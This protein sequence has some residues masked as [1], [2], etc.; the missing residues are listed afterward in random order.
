VEPWAPRVEEQL[1]LKRSDEDDVGFDPALQTLQ[2]TQSCRP[3]LIRPRE[4]DLESVVPRD[5]RGRPGKLLIALLNEP[6]K[7]SRTRPQTRID[8]RERVLPVGLAHDEVS[9]RLQQRQECDKKEEEPASETAEA[10]FQ[11]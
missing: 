7:N 3:I 4:G 6:A 10:K 2:R 11:G 5:N 9:R 1:F 8:L